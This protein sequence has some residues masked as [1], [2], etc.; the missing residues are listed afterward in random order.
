MCSSHDKRMFSRL[1]LQ[2]TMVVILLLA[3]AS[4]GKDKEQDARLATLEMSVAAAASASKD[5]VAQAQ[6]VASAEA[7]VSSR[8][9]DVE[10]RT[11]GIGY[12]SPGWSYR[13]I[14]G[15]NS[16]SIR[17]TP[18][19]DK[20]DICRISGS[21]EYSGALSSPVV[22]TVFKQGGESAFETSVN[23]TDGAFEVGAA[24]INCALVNKVSFA[25][26]N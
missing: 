5:A 17:A 13:G 21:F 23:L 4:C 6:A 22:L 19:K 16:L 10:E 11:P 25:P 14:R 20:P 3:V 2:V 8:L 18:V 24:P 9:A 1:A 15:A 12:F 7:T 26:K